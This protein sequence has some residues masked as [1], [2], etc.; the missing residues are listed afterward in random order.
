MQGKATHDRRPTSLLIVGDTPYAVVDGRLQT[1]AALSKQLDLWCAEFDEVRIAAHRIDAPQPGFRSLARDDIELVD[2]PA[3]G[4]SGLTAKLGVV[5][6][7]F[8]WVAVLAPLMRRS[9]AVHLRTPCNVTL[10]AIP[11]ARVLCPR[12][13]AIFAGTWE[14]TDSEPRSYR[15]QRGM[16]RHVGG[17]V[18]AYVPPDDDVPAHIRPNVSPSF[19]DQELDALAPLAQ[20]R[21]DRIASDP[22]AQRALRICCVGAFSERKNQAGL[23]RAVALLA[24]RGVPVKL[25]FAGTGRTFEADQ[26]LA[27]ELGIADR[28]RFLGQLGAADLED[29]FAWADVHALVTFGEGFGKVFIEAMAVGCPSVVGSGRMQL[30]IIGSGARGRQA[31]PASPAS[32]ARCLEELRA[33]GPDEQAAMVGSCTDHARTCTIDAFAH[34][35]RHITRDLWSLPAPSSP[36]TANQEVPTC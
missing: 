25:R 24:E 19:S 11:L 3:G 7:L 32:I 4:G 21:L 1:F 27:R 12:R 16:L 2:L 5:A 14:R 26:A 17:V 8:R 36:T 22:V 30:A 28:T 15:L 9:T 18:H 31:D 35:V 6:L 13:Y 23:L 20:Q 34:E 10:V 33:L 29:L